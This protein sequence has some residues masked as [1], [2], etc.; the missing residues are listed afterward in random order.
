M[1]KEVP[2]M[3][4]QKIFSKILIAA[5]VTDSIC[6]WGA[7]APHTIKSWIRPCDPLINLLVILVI[8]AAVLV[9]RGQGRLGAPEGGVAAA[10]LVE[11]TYIWY[12]TM[13]S[14]QGCL[15]GVYRGTNITSMTNIK[16][17]LK[18]TEHSVKTTAFRCK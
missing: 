18:N 13:I 7:P 12:S 1:E 3:K 9:Q 4:A 6:Y 5:S 15:A 10:L 14:V 17:T 8:A 16:I 11:D 2:Y